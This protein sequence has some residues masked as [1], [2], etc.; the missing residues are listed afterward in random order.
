MIIAV[1][2][3]KGGVGK[4]TL[5]THA[6]RHLAFSTGEP[7]AFYDAD[8]QHDGFSWLVGHDKAAIEKGTV[9]LGD[10]TTQAPTGAIVTVELD[11]ALA[12][13]NVLVDAPPREDFLIRLREHVEPDLLI[14][15]V[16]GRLA[17]D[18][19]VNVL[20][21]AEGVRAV[22]VFNMTDPKHEFSR[23]EAAAVRKLGA[24][25]YPV[26]IPRNDAVRKGELLGIPAWNVP[27]AE[28]THAVQALRGFCE[29]VG[30][31]AGA[32]PAPELAQRPSNGR[33]DIWDR[34]NI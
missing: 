32:F 13:T 3:N 29:W 18:G 28:R 33:A 17:V 30:T 27:H 15:P 21:A 34:L 9:E 4:T 6:F 26:A 11:T 22:V 10:S 12:F 2:N 25:L 24:E 19:A 1:Y 5:A 23:S 8:P 16:N 20:E 31:G 14:V 7:W